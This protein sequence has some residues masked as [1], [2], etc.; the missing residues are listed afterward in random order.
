MKWPDE[1]EGAPQAAINAFMALYKATLAMGKDATR[2]KQDAMSVVFDR[3][4]K[5]EDGNWLE[6]SAGASVENTVQFRASVQPGAG[7]VWDAVLIVSGISQT[8][9]PF[10]WPET[11][12]QDAVELFTGVDINAYELQADFFT[13][14]PIS[15]IS[16]LED[17]KRYLVAKK[18]GTVRRAW[19]SDGEGIR[20]EIEF[21]QG[22]QWLPD[23]LR[24]DPN[25]LGLSIDARVHG[26]EVAVEGMTVFWVTR[27]ASSS[28]VDVVTYPA[29]GGKFIRAIQ[30]LTINKG[31]NIMTKEQLLALIAKNRPDLLNG[32]DQTTM[33]DDEVSTLA[34]MAMTPSITK[35]DQPVVQ[36]LD[37]DQVVAIVK[38]QTKEVA[39]RAACGRILDRTLDTCNLP[40]PAV[41]R[42]RGKFEGQIFD[43]IELNT[44]ITSERDYI[45]AMSAPTGLDLPDQTRMRVGSGPLDRAQMAIDK[46]FGLEKADIQNMARMSRLDNKPFFSDMRAAQAYDGF[47]DVPAFSG[48]REMYVFFTGDPDVTGRFNRQNLSPDLRAAQDITSATFAYVLGNTLAR[49]LIKDY[50]AIDYQENLLISIRKSV[51]DFKQQE[52]IM[53]GYFPDLSTVDPEAAD[54]S[55]IAAVT[56]EESNYT[57]GQ[58]GNILTITR[59]TIINDDQSIVQ[60]LL[61]RL[62]RSARRT[63]AKYVW[64]KFINNATCSDGTAWFTGGHGNLTT[65][66]L[67]FATALAGYQALAKM[68]EKGSGERIGLL[69]DPSVKPVLIYP[70]D[71]MATGD[72]IVN[73]DSYYSSNDLTTKVR[74]SLK[75]KIAGA[76]IT[77]L[78]D[79]T[80]WGLL[81]P[82]GVADMVEMG[83]LNGR[84]EPEMFVADTP[85]SEQV[86]VADKIR[87]KIRHE[88]AGAVVDYRSGYK[89]VVAG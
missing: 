53:V 75:G 6:S 16:A 81:L 29:A 57:I 17:I 69:D 13:H 54:Y 73:E 22:Q 70:V 41:D 1:L 28:S 45:A 35:P 78:T 50:N 25:A 32:K 8:S 56:D 5:Q 62:G 30:G 68:T 71:L 23:M 48:L 77:L 14:L 84:Q 80:D 19:W 10:Y 4:K 67:S 55:E 3:W 36:G 61:S 40:K 26:Y 59:K 79:V 7:L 33:T 38:V 24:Q 89:G 52:A 18:V 20:G 37:A 47:D 65:G 15:D 21:Y 11:V 43:Q 63:H 31:K 87:N 2:A 42:I 76:M 34:Q 46:M 58:K 74:N 64:D 88:Y 86:F 39:Q 27:I 85:Q 60:R 66:V 72:Q 44:E 49:R 12:L 9:P 82:P 83:Y 51:R